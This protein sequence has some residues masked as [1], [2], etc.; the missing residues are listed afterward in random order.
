MES[1]LGPLFRSHHLLRATSRLP[2]LN[3]DNRVIPGLRSFARDVRRRD[4]RDSPGERVSVRCPGIA[5]PQLAKREYVREYVQKAVPLPLPPLPM[6]AAF[7]PHQDSTYKWS[8]RVSAKET[9]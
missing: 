3:M 5:V 1:N 8:Q 7:S 6:D 2:D 4:G 9:A